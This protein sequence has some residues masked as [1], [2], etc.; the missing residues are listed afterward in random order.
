MNSMLRL[1]FLKDHP[2]R[3]VDYRRE[4]VKTGRPVRRQESRYNIIVNQIRVVSG[5]AA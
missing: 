3:H 2:D 4:R 1:P 5:K